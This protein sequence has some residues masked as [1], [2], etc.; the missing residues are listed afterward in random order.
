MSILVTEQKLAVALIDLWAQAPNP[1][2]EK[3]PCYLLVALSQIAS[4][5][6][7]VVGEVIKLRSDPLLRL[8]SCPDE[9]A[10][11]PVE[12]KSTPNLVQGEGE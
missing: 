3:S 5:L 4:G 8:I 2:E 1:E 6:G 12:G 11:E 9:G 7:F 10:T